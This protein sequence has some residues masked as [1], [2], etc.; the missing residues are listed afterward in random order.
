MI[1]FASVAEIEAAF[2]DVRAFYEREIVDVLNC[3]EVAVVADEGA[4]R[5][6]DGIVHRE[7]MGNGSCK[8]GIDEGI[9]EAV[10]AND[11]FVGEVFDR[12]EAVVDGHVAGLAKGI[13]GSRDTGKGLQSAID[14]VIE[15]VLVACG[16][17]SEERI[18]L[19][20]D[21]VDLVR[22]VYLPVVGRSR[23]I[24]ASRV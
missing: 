12:A 9:S 1:D 15:G 2:D 19:V 17:A 13:H 22:S 21:V 11:Q 6:G 20:E 23:E 18:L 4:K 10:E 24:I 3:G 7:R 16:D 14:N 5:I 8:A